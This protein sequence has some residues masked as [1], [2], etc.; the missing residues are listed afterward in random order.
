MFKNGKITETEYVFWLDEHADVCEENYESSSGGMEAAGALELWGRSDEHEMR[1]RTFVSDGDSSAYLAVCG[2][3]NGKG[4]YGDMYPIE[5]AECI[6][7]VAKRLGTGLRG[8]KKDRK[9]V[10]G[11]KEQ[12]H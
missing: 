7:H 9:K 12:A 4:P 10:N 6:N 1:Y 2:M 11:R 3:N 5:K 8:I